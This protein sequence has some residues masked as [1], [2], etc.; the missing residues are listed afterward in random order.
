[1]S[2]FVIDDEDLSDV[3]SSSSSEVR[4]NQEETS[5]FAFL[6]DD[7]FKPKEQTKSIVLTERISFIV[8]SNK[9]SYDALSLT[10]KKQIISQSDGWYYGCS[11][12]RQR[13]VPALYPLTCSAALRFIE[14]ERF[15]QSNASFLDIQLQVLSEVF[16]KVSVIALA[17]E[18]LIKVQW[19][20]QCFSALARITDRTIIIFHDFGT[21]EEGAYSFFYPNE[22]KASLVETKAPIFLIQSN[23]DFGFL[24]SRSRS[25]LVNFNLSPTEVSLLNTVST[26][27]KNPVYQRLVPLLS[28][29]TFS[30]EG[31]RDIFEI[32]NFI[33]Y[34]ILPRPE[35]NENMDYIDPNYQE[36]VNSL[37][38]PFIYDI[39]GGAINNA[40]Q[41]LSAA[42]ILNENRRY[43]SRTEYN[44]L[45]VRMAIDKYRGI[46]TSISDRN[47]FRVF[48][49]ADFTAASIVFNANILI[50]YRDDMGIS[51]YSKIPAPNR[52]PLTILLEYNMGTF[53]LLLPARLNDAVIGAYNTPYTPAERKTNGFLNTLGIKKFE[54]FSRIVYYITPNFSELIM[55][56]SSSLS[57]RKK[58]LDVL[59]KH[60]KKKKSGSGYSSESSES[61]VPRKSRSS[62][63]QRPLPS[64]SS[65][66]QDDE[67][68]SSM[69]KQSEEEE[70]EYKKE[71]SEFNEITLN[72]D[73]LI[74]PLVMK[75]SNTRRYKFADKDDT[76]SL[77]DNFKL[78]I[79]PNGKTRRQFNG[80]LL[81]AW[82]TEFSSQ[83]GRRWPTI[84]TS[85]PLKMVFMHRSIPV[86][87]YSAEFSTTPPETAQDKFFTNFLNRF[88]SN[89]EPI[90]KTYTSS[91]HD[92]VIYAKVNKVL[93]FGVFRDNRLPPLE[94]GLIDIDGFMKFFDL[95]GGFVEL[96]KMTMHQYNLFRIYASMIQDI[97]DGIF[98]SHRMTDRI[99]WFL[100]T[101]LLKTHPH[102]L[103]DNPV[104]TDE[105]TA[106]HGHLRELF[107]VKL[108]NI[109]FKSPCFKWQWKL[110]HLWLFAYLC[111]NPDQATISVNYL[112]S[113]FQE[114]VK[115]NGFNNNL[116]HNTSTA[117]M[118]RFQ[119][120]IVNQVVSQASVSISKDILIQL[121]TWERPIDSEITKLPLYSIHYPLLF[122]INTPEDNK[123]SLSV[124]DLYYHNQI[125]DMIIHIQ[126]PSGIKNVDNLLFSLQTIDGL[127]ITSYRI[128]GFPAV[129]N[130]NKPPAHE[131]LTG[132]KLTPVNIKKTARF[133]SG[134]LETD[135]SKK[136]SSLDTARTSLLF[137]RIEKTMD[138]NFDSKRDLSITKDPK[139]SKYLE[140]DNKTDGWFELSEDKNYVWDPEISSIERKESFSNWRSQNEDWRS[141]IV[142][143]PKA[144]FSFQA[145]QTTDLLVRVSMKIQSAIEEKKDGRR[146]DRLRVEI[147]TEMMNLL[148]TAQQSPDK[149]YAMQEK[150]AR[151]LSSLGKIASKV[152]NLIKLWNGM[153]G[154]VISFNRSFLQNHGMSELVLP[155]F[156]FVEEKA[157]KE[158]VTAL[159]NALNGLISIPDNMTGY[160]VIR[161]LTE[162]VKALSVPPIPLPP[163]CPAV[164]PSQILKSEEFV[165]PPFHR[166]LRNCVGLSLVSTEMIK[167][168]H[169]SI[170]TQ[171]SLRSFTRRI[172]T[173]IASLDRIFVQLFGVMPFVNIWAFPVGKYNFEN[174]SVNIVSYVRRRRDEIIFSDKEIEHIIESRYLPHVL[175]PEIYRNAEEIA[176][177]HEKVT[178]V[179]MISETPLR[180]TT[181]Q[182]VINE[183][184]PFENKLVRSPST[185][186]E[187]ARFLFDPDFR[188]FYNQTWAFLSGISV[189]SAIPTQSNMNTNPETLGM[190]HQY[191]DFLKNIILE[192]KNTSVQDLYK[193][194][195]I[196]CDCLRVK[197]SGTT[198]FLKM[199]YRSTVADIH[200]TRRP[201]VRFSSGNSRLASSVAVEYFI[202]YQI[203]RCFAA[204]PDNF[205]TSDH[206]F[207]HAPLLLEFMG[208]REVSN[209][210]IKNNNNEPFDVTT[211]SHLITFKVRIADEF[212]LSV[213]PGFS[214]YYIRGYEY[215]KTLADKRKQPVSVLSV[216]NTAVTI[217]TYYPKTSGK[218]TSI[219][220]FTRLFNYNSRLLNFV[221]WHGLLSQRRYVP[222]V[223]S[224]FSESRYATMYQDI[225][226]SLFEGFDM[227]KPSP[228][229]WKPN[230]PSQSYTEHA[231]DD[232]T[233]SKYDASNICSFTWSFMSME[234][235]LGWPYPMGHYD[236]TKH[237]AFT[238]LSHIP[239]I[240]KSTKL[241]SNR[242]KITFLLTDFLPF[243][244]LES[245]QHESP[246]SSPSFPSSNSTPSSP[247]DDT[248]LT[249]AFLGAG[250][251]DDGLMDAH[252]DQ[253]ESGGLGGEE[254]FFLFTPREA[255]NVAKKITKE[256]KNQNDAARARRKY[257]AKILNNSPTF[258][259]DLFWYLFDLP[260]FDKTKTQSS[261]DSEQ[262]LRI[263]RLENYRVDFPEAL[264]AAEDAFSHTRLVRKEAAIKESRASRQQKAASTSSSNTPEVVTARD[265]SFVNTSSFYQSRQL[266]SIYESEKKEGRV[267]VSQTPEAAEDEIWR[268]RYEFLA[269]TQPDVDVRFPFT[270]IYPRTSPMGY[271]LKQ[272]DELLNSG[273]LDEES[274]RKVYRSVTQSV[275]DF[276]NEFLFLQDYA[277]DV[278]MLQRK[279]NSDKPLSS[280]RYRKIKAVLTA[281]LAK[282]FNDYGFLYPELKLVCIM[283][284]ENLYTILTRLLC[285]VTNEALLRDIQASLWHEWIIAGYTVVFLPMFQVY[286]HLRV[287][288][289]DTHEVSSDDETETTTSLTDDPQQLPSSSSINEAIDMIADLLDDVEVS[290]SSSSSEK[291][292]DE[293]EFYHTWFSTTFLSRETSKKFLDAAITQL[294]RDVILFKEESMHHMDRFGSETI[295]KQKFLTNHVIIPRFLWHE[296]SDPLIIANIL[297]RLQFA[298]GASP[299]TQPPVNSASLT[300]QAVNAYA[301]NV[302]KQRFNNIMMPL[303]DLKKPK[304]EFNSTFHAIP[305]S[306]KIDGKIGISTLLAYIPEI[307]DEKHLDANH[308][309]REKVEFFDNAAK[310]YNEVSAEI[311]KEYKET[312]LALKTVD[313]YSDDILINPRLLS[314]ILTSKNP[315]ESFNAYKEVFLLRCALKNY[316]ISHLLVEQNPQKSPASNQ[317]NSVMQYIKLMK[318]I[319]ESPFDEV[320]ETIDAIFTVRSFNALLEN[321]VDVPSDII[322]SF[323]AP[324]TT[325]T[326]KRVILRKTLL[327]LKLKELQDKYPVPYQK[328]QEQYDTLLAFRSVYHETEHRKPDK[329]A[330]ATIFAAYAEMIEAYNL[331]G[332]ATRPRGNNTMMQVRFMRRKYEELKRKNGSS[333]KRVKY[334]RRI[335]QRL[336]ETEPTDENVFA[337]LEETE[338][339]FHQVELISI[340]DVPTDNNMRSNPFDENPAR[341]TLMR[342]ALLQFVF[343]K[344]FPPQLSRKQFLNNE[345]NTYVSTLIASNDEKTHLEFVLSVLNPALDSILRIDFRDKPVKRP[346]AEL[347]TLPFKSLDTDM[348]T[349][350]VDSTWS[351][352]PELF[353][354]VFTPKQIQDAVQRL[355]FHYR[356]INDREALRELASQSNEEILQHAWDTRL[357]PSSIRL[358]RQS[359]F[360]ENFNLGPEYVITAI[361]NYILKTIVDNS[362]DVDAFINGAFGIYNL[363]WDLTKTLQIL[364]SNGVISSDENV[365]RDANKVISEESKFSD[366]V[367]IMRDYLTD[368][369]N[370]H[371]ITFTHFIN[372]FNMTCLSRS[373]IFLRPS[374][375]APLIAY[376][377]KRASAESLA[378]LLTRLKIEF[379]PTEESQGA[380][381]KKI[382]V[383]AA[384]LSARNFPWFKKSSTELINFLEVHLECRFTPFEKEIIDFAWSRAQGFTLEK[385]YGLVVSFRK[386]DWGSLLSVHDLIDLFAKQPKIPGSINFSVIFKSLGDLELRKEL[387][388]R[389]KELYGVPL[390]VVETDFIRC[391]S[392]FGIPPEIIKQCFIINRPQALYELMKTRILVSSRF[393]KTPVEQRKDPHVVKNIISAAIHD[394]VVVTQESFS[395]FETINTLDVTID[396]TGDLIQTISE[397]SVA[398]DLPES[399]SQNIVMTDAILE[400]YLQAN[401]K[402]HDVF[403]KTRENAFK[404]ANSS[405]VSHGVESDVLVVPLALEGGLEVGGEIPTFLDLFN[406]SNS[407]MNSRGRYNVVGYLPADIHIE[408]DDGNTLFKT[409]SYYLSEDHTLE[410]HQ[411]HRDEVLLWIA[412]NLDTPLSDNTD[413]TFRDV[414]NVPLYTGYPVDESI[415]DS[416][417]KHKM[418]ERDYYLEYIRSDTFWNDFVFLLAASHVYNRPVHIVTS[419]AEDS[420][421]HSIFYP[422]YATLD[423]TPI[424]ILCLNMIYFLPLVSR[425]LSNTG[426]STNPLPS[427]SSLE[428]DSSSSSS[429]LEDDYSSSSSSLEDDS[430]F[431]GTSR[432]KWCYMAHEHTIRGHTITPA[433]RRLFWYHCKE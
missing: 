240:Y 85:K 145:M 151:R 228:S 251:E 47:R 267:F 323:N 3:T 405:G 99:L 376:M 320:K 162:K 62:V 158:R 74:M 39:E 101:F 114:R 107:T 117:L 431:I 331:E 63:T 250:L 347:I 27:H 342:Q 103:K 176:L 220:T 402:F 297:E 227:I 52:N 216:S 5:N 333:I 327:R 310:D 200:A 35:D 26:T 9:Q 43:S 340:Y 181:S 414:I 37:Q 419:L 161:E 31:R 80:N 358:F 6:R 246:P 315:S 32:I 269:Q 236:T 350:D 105:M 407:I 41:A 318:A 1:M 265:F 211:I 346:D 306:S 293:S 314:A 14:P 425:N 87:G 326:Q 296:D 144:T 277:N 139:L 88:F 257:L 234:N 59:A 160:T 239:I 368:P 185:R 404:V 272:A 341:K 194:F 357:S 255:H 229:P 149:T 167:R 13:Q 381:L 187:N 184:I 289:T 351:L 112:R 406:T 370:L 233:A 17:P 254:G 281:I 174:P 146:F 417:E 21:S 213:T 282:E 96:H 279:V 116:Y 154:K 170:A 147:Y 204:F 344:A 124:V 389:S 324:L 57:E 215:G 70:E 4:L 97:D 276:D 291:P 337:L 163:P 396:Q 379:N 118:D 125:H 171:E 400:S 20:E 430:S 237:T 19:D 23:R 24:Y 300:P 275:Y 377:M 428:D 278:A 408:L 36:V 7:S 432:E 348:F 210:G 86:D 243:K 61:D 392:L 60:I 366:G 84:F 178:R 58:R 336:Y 40:P 217:P 166:L 123:P 169:T 253:N 16:S 219:F 196:S 354:K 321:H 422:S 361:N 71:E 207:L 309:R 165:Q 98:S 155:K 42:L 143:Y 10:Q 173:C 411:I 188:R 90:E 195:T 89:S 302:T 223:I 45:G 191:F 189:Y 198:P 328:E 179:K 273:R 66:L 349:F 294:L 380:L 135:N 127:P 115:A 199:P 51:F 12:A 335:L 212:V 268:Q 136:D 353:E 92:F 345:A 197:T 53:F 241:F 208:I 82:R 362:G 258:L 102:F 311:L 172:R 332:A 360:V 416:P 397:E 424:P 375:I 38:T 387:S 209:T 264:W 91:P 429:S 100:Y 312:T 249:S 372:F 182:I 157:Q 313:R 190:N 330:L 403:A 78:S 44:F 28:D 46:T 398:E 374:N 54:A 50:R 140:L 329:I 304:T 110:S 164:A 305:E 316:T 11:K 150:G 260:V 138:Y 369:N 77:I 356:R 395:S 130:P 153:E 420:I 214:N 371:T 286:E 73:I 283:M 94:D 287:D 384:E 378:P 383:V 69:L 230:A 30:F 399:Y 288:I 382:K 367:V 168:H 292:S 137:A 134:I 388:A 128:D 218:S 319:N 113:V 301:E 177:I 231:S 183:L 364:S 359:T 355:R 421:W 49:L 81:F 242:Q 418:M 129:L 308:R 83:K 152:K 343:E 15:D 120:S 295:K 393:D 192:G 410:N 261:F 386:H 156:L 132:P 271:T 262:R 391:C 394:S 148:N 226:E 68:H 133:T 104:I 256:Y 106:T 22:N 121:I 303:K 252:F 423:Q 245:L 67:D 426:T 433:Q 76:I 390:S 25:D 193:K 401:K 299:F 206:F 317:Q 232:I 111:L 202:E 338:Q 75:N 325:D 72:E 79:F 412:A 238:L 244:P 307:E 247:Y 33:P 385:A 415:Q 203:D 285:R 224:Y 64:S 159:E 225:K 221:F 175:L 263:R 93:P 373:R 201:D 352:N 334:Y 290:P 284:S 270:G 2:K 131:F 248:F 322:A 298:F 339:F 34:M 413:L 48:D 18:D 8:F 122:G 274:R 95:I 427:S 56:G 363:A 109:L 186:S 180:K 29:Y 108:F 222:Q 409:I 126:T 266:A 65:L 259:E 280:V 205:S 142:F 55:K 119:E 235:M 141:I 365:S